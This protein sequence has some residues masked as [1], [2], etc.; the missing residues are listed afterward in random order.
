MQGSERVKMLFS[1]SFAVVE[2]ISTDTEHRVLPRK[3]LEHCLS[4]IVKFLV[5]TQCTYCYSVSDHLYHE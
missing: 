5:L 3:A 4:I 2:K 1:Y